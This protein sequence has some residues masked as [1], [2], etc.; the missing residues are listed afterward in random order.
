[1]LTFLGIAIVILLA[2]ILVRI[3]IYHDKVIQYRMAV[4]R[5]QDIRHQALQGERETRKAQLTQI[6]KRINRLEQPKS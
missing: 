4:E 1:M 6:R 5:E 3:E 2:S